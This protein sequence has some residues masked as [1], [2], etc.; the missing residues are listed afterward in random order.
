MPYPQNSPPNP[1]PLTSEP[2][3]TT[4]QCVYFWATSSYAGFPSGP[5]TPP[6]AP[7]TQEL[8]LTRVHIGP[9]GVER[10]SRGG[11]WEDSC[12]Q[13][14][15]RGGLLVGG[16][17]R[18]HCWGLL[19]LTIRLLLPLCPGGLVSHRELW[20]RGRERQSPGRGHL[21]SP[22][23][24]PLNFWNFHGYFLTCTRNGG[25]ADKNLPIL[26]GVY[27]QWNIIQP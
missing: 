4:T 21:L 9:A 24:Q 1:K 17:G 25:G 16:W 8:R 14:L 11:W 23:P 26:C 18:R 13:P 27:I 20:S 2:H 15:P 5:T 10:H 7:A 12:L 6:D 19:L 22:L 3:T